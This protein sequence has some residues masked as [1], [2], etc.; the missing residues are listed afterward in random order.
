IT[1][2]NDNFCTISGYARDE[3]VGKPHNIVRHPDMPKEIFEELWNDISNGKT[4]QGVIKNRQKYGNDYYVK[5]TIFPMFDEK[6]DIIEYIGLREDITPIETAKQKAQEADQIKTNFMAN[7]SHEIRTPINGIA[8]FAD[9]LSQTSLDTKQT[10]YLSVINNSINAL[11]HIVDNILDFSNIQSGEMK[12]ELVNINLHNELDDFAKLFLPTAHEKKLDYIF[13]LDDN[14]HNCLKTDIQHLKQI[15]NKLI[16][17]AIKFTDHG[18]KV[19]V[20]VD[21]L[22]D[23]TTQQVIK[24]SIADTGIG[25]KQEHLRSI[26]DTFSQVDLSDTRKF[27]GTGL[28]LSIANALV[29]VMGGVLHVESKEDEGSLFS[30]QLTA[31]KC[32]SGVFDPDHSDSNPTLANPYNDAIAYAA[33]L[34]NLDKTIIKRLF[35]KFLISVCEDIE[36][37]NLAI[38]NKMYEEIDQYAQRIE[39]A[40]GTIGLT[41]IQRQIREI[42][43]QALNKNA[44]YDYAN[45][46]AMVSNNIETLKESMKSR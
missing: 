41:T 32:H 16:G 17:N 5:S 23:T 36:K 2:V 34:L 25:I 10:R 42:K 24:F 1:K 43:D 4:W 28:G 39:A 46:V 21:I 20:S 11:V 26:F 30:F 15:L 45:T 29:K 22:N 9:L 19:H 27:G 8:G 40:S 14:L 18:G 3:L 44:D 37:L 33:E 6:G 31:E 38:N 13:K 7:M 35:D 12:L